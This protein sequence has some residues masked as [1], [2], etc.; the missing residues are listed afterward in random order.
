LHQILESIPFS[1]T[2]KYSQLAA[3]QIKKGRDVVK[4]TAGEPDFPTPREIVEEAKKALDEGFT[5]YTANAG[6]E[7][8]RK[9]ISK[10]LKARYNI[11][12]SFSEI[13][14]SNGGKQAIYNS[15]YA[16]TEPEDEVMIIVPDWVSYFPLVKLCQCNAV[17]VPTRFENDFL[18]EI[19]E[20]EKRVSTRTKALIINSPNNPTGA[21]YPLELITKIADIAKN[22]DFW[23]IS[24]EIY[25][26]L[27]FEGEHNSI[28]S[29]NQMKERTIVI[30]GFSKSHSMTGWRCGYSAAPEK[31]TRQIGKFQSHV[32][33][34]INSITQKA[35]LKAVSVDNS[36]MLEEFRR[37]RNFITKGLDK[38][39]IRYVKPSGAFYVF[40]DFSE[41][42]GKFDD[43]DKLTINLLEEYG[44]GLVPGSAFHKPGFMRLSF[45]SSMEDLGKALERLE[46]FVNEN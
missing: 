46:K 25:S 21:V 22:S 34:N 16:I 31:I 43:D 39:G 23:V 19:S 44:V 26:T 11:D 12:Y 18:P 28:A 37:R 41:F 4:L 9:A 3:D 6:I 10:D 14:M 20:I 35:A 33:Y 1:T 13:V 40:M 30:N 2:I 32:T 45:A 15:L 7:E 38:I 42:V 24:D 5:K 17:P 29:L 36:D 27:V 8:L